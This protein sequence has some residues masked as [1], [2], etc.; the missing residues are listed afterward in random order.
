MRTSSTPAGSHH[1]ATSAAATAR[2]PPTLLHAWNLGKERL[3][4][5]DPAETHVGATL[6][7]DGRKRVL[8]LV[9]CVSIYTEPGGHGAATL[10]VLV[11]MRSWSPDDDAAMFIA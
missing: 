7:G 1:P 4:S 5:E 3:F 11:R 9:Q 2:W 8:C 6:H 10:L